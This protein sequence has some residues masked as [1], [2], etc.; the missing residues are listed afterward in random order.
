MFLRIL[1]F[2]PPIDCDTSRFIIQNYFFF[3]CRFIYPVIAKLV[4]G[5]FMSISVSWACVRSTLCILHWEKNHAYI[6]SS[7]HKQ[8]AI[9]SLGLCWSLHYYFWEEKKLPSW[10][11][12]L[13]FLPVVRCQHRVTTSTRTES[14]C[15]FI[16]FKTII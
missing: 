4:H 16:R 11:S 5:R 6:K 12:L 9:S 8:L 10:Y 7:K 13:S 15:F 1:D 14:C 2:G 3:A